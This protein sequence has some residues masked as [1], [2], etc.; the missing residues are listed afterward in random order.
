MLDKKKCGILRLAD[1]RDIVLG[2]AGAG[3]IKPDDLQKKALNKCSE[4]AR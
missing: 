3:V 2:A 4:I 1:G